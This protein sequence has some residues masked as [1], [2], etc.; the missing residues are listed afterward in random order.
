MPIHELECR[1]CGYK[2]E[3]LMLKSGS[4]LLFCPKCKVLMHRVMAASNFILKGDCWA[5]DRYK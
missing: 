2:Q 1:K 5:K 3:K 4:P